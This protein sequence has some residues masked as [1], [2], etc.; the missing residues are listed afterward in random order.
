MNKSVSIIYTALT[1]VSLSC[2]TGCAISPPPNVRPEEVN[3]ASLDP[4]NWYIYYSAEMSSHPSA[5]PKGAWSFEFP[6]SEVGGHVNYVQ[7]PFNA[8]TTLHNV[9]A[10][11]RIESDTPRY[12]VM[13]SSDI[14]PATVH[15]FFEQQ[16]DDLVDPNGR[17]WATASLYN[18]GSQ[19]NTTITFVVPLTPDQWSNVHGKRDPNSFYAALGNVGWIGM[20]FGGQS[21][22][23]HGVALTSGSAKYILVD[24]NVN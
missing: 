21:F 16:N 12:K 5:D 18:L 19:D 13:D 3:V 4:Q 20:T 10:I 23:G 24:L 15:I 8:T 9:T 14:L 1:L 7:T 2:L 17:W 11:F 22:F 6:S